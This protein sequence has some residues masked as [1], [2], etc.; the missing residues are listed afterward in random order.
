M[1]H[2]G[3]NGNRCHNKN[4]SEVELWQL[5]RWESDDSSVCNSLKVKDC[6]SVWIC[7]SQEMEC[8]GK[9]IGDNYTHKDW[10]DL[11]HSLAPDIK[12]NNGS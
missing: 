1:F 2:H 4:G 7:K 9:Y 8:Q 11:K 6:I 12:D 10:N 3:C 5:E